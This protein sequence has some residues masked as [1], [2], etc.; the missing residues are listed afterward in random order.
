[1]GFQHKKI[2]KD[3]GKR[4]VGRLHFQRAGGSCE[5]ALNLVE[6]RFCE[7]IRLG[8]FI[9]QQSGLSVN[10]GGTAD[11]DS[12]LPLQKVFLYVETDSINL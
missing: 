9:N 11:L 2:M 8:S 7:S 6:T 5:P 3:M 12:S 4:I 1:M 10:Q